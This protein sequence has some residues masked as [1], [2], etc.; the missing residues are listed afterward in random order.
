VISG[1]NPL[2]TVCRLQCDDRENGKDIKPVVVAEY[3]VGCVW[4][5]RESKA[6]WNYTLLEGFGKCHVIIVSQK[7]VIIAI[8]TFCHGQA[9]DSNC[10]S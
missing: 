5:N 10:S 4:S 6:M 1:G 8:N 3:T 7:I 2:G 9:S